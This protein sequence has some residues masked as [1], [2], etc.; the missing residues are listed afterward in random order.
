MAE[1][2]TAAPLTGGGCL[3]SSK[4]LCGTRLLHK[5]SCRTI[6]LCQRQEA[7]QIVQLT[8]CHH[9]QD[10]GRTLAPISIVLTREYGRNTN[11]HLTGD[12]CLRANL[13][14]LIVQVSRLLVELDWHLEVL[15][16]REVHQTSSI[17]VP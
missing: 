14:D 1:T 3:S 4:K 9:G 6:R 5:Q 13:L 15:D 8:P 16:W 10:I 12:Q 17:G 2:A 7:Y 11:T